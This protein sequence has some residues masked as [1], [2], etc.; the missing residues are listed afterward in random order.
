VWL[1]GRIVRAARAR[2][3]VTERGFLYGDG[4]FETVRTYQGRPFLLAAHLAR[5]RRSARFFSLPVA[6][7]ARSWTRSIGRLL[8]A[9]R[10]TDAAVRLTVTRGTAAG[11][12]PPLRARPTLLLEA[13]PL[14]ADLAA[15]Q[16]AGVDVC[17]L[18]FARGTGPFVAHKTLAYLPAVLG[19]RHARL[20]GAHDGLYV[21]PEGNVTEATTANLFV[22][23]R[24]RLRTPG[25]GVLPGVTRDLVITLARRLGLVTEERPVGRPLLATAGEAFLTSSVVEI[26]PVV[27]VDDHP[28]GSGVPGP[29]TRALQDAYRRR[30]VAAIR[31]KI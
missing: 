24:G 6:G 21:T 4:L 30:V 28:V 18:P 22:W 20:R 11:L 5:L 10:L 7:T 2:L 27:R 13:R 9:N 17:L 15:H 1:N 12:A 8:A 29:V 19:R 3:A 23:Y 14:D 31:R 16:A 26:L 25:T